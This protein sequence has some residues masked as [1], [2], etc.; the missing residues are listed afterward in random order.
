M[1]T[2]Y[3]TRADAPAPARWAPLTISAMV[4]V[5]F[6]YLAF[7]LSFAALTA[8]ALRHGVAADVVWMFAV[9]VDGGAVVGTVGVVMARRAGRSSRPYWATV[10]GFAAISLTFNIAH[11]DGSMLGVAIAVTP[12]LAQLVATELLVRLL[13]TPGDTAGAAAGPSIAAAIAAAG[14]ATAAVDAITVAARAAED[15]ATAARAAAG[16]ATAAAVTVTQETQQLTAR[17]GASDSPVADLDLA[18][19]IATTEVMPPPAAPIDSGDLP[20]RPQPLA[21]TFTAPPLTAGEYVHDPGAE[22]DPALVVP[23]SWMDAYR[24]VRRETGKRPTQE[25]LGEALG[26]KRTRASQIREQ[27]ETALNTPCV[28]IVS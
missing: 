5:G 18:A 22:P 2:A 12:P 28:V 7:R 11:S 23:Q 10:I 13:P 25:G 15:A 24:Q 26:V 14:R 6:A 20:P 17:H 3:P 1:A 21:A 8:L 9:L 4:T 27:I 19:L 16:E